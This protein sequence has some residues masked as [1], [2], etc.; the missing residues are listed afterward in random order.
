MRLPSAL[1]L[2]LAVGLAVSGCAVAATPGASTGGS[3]AAPTSSRAP[4][5]GTLGQPSSA[6]TL[7]PT[8]PVGSQAAGPHLSAIVACSLLDVPTASSL[9]GFPVKEFG[10][11]DPQARVPFKDTVGLTASGVPIRQSTCGYWE[12]TTAYDSRTLTVGIMQGDPAKPGTW[13]AETAHAHFLVVLGLAAAFKPQAIAG[14]GDEAFGWVGPGSA[15]LV[16]RSS[17]VIVVVEVDW[18]AANSVSLDT[19]QSVVR[20]VL[21]KL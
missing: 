13:S 11:A 1:A 17:D 19:M 3:T 15:R 20:A 2:M 16:T 8:T 18:G 14:L 7:A 4:A 10:P 9:V 21:A 6:P 5:T 12:P